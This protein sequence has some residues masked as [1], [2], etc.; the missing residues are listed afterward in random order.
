VSLAGAEVSESIDGSLLTCSVSVRVGS[1]E[2]RFFCVLVGFDEIESDSA[3][4]SCG[5]DGPDCFEAAGDGVSE[6]LERQI[7]VV[8][9]HGCSFSWI[10]VGR[11]PLLRGER[12]GEGCS[13]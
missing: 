2:L 11:H 3:E 5:A 8:V 10:L 4:E 6:G 1:R 13:G 12:L 9:E 7:L